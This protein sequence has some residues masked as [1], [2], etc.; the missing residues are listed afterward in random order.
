MLNFWFY[1]FNIFFIVVQVQFS[2]FPPHPSLPPQP[3]PPPSPVSTPL[4]YCPRVLYNRSCKPFTLSPYNPLPFPLWSLSLKFFKFGLC[5]EV[6]IKV[7]ECQFSGLSYT[8]DAYSNSSFNIAA[9][10]H[11][12][13]QT[14]LVIVWKRVW[15]KAF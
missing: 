9:S 11:S 2:A 1:F 8:Y 14:S 3:S 7:S 5:I 15:L 6:I 10:L 13:D 12:R 4:C